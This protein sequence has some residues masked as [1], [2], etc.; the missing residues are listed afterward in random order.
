MKIEAESLLQVYAVKCETEA[1]KILKYT[2]T[3]RI[4]GL[5]RPFNL[6]EE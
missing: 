1:S 5:N 2:C 3:V 6:S 4:L